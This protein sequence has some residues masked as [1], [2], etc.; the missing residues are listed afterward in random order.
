MLTL[1][2]S[3][4]SSF[5]LMPFIA[6]GAIMVGYNTY[7]FFR[8]H[9][10]LG[11]SGKAEAITSAV[12]VIILNAVIV[13]IPHGGLGK[14]G[15][16]GMLAL[17]IN[18]MYVGVA[19]WYMKK[20]IMNAV[21]STQDDL[22]KRASAFS[23]TAFRKATMGFTALLLVPASEATP[24]TKKTEVA[25]RIKSH[26]A[27]SHLPADELVT[28]F[29]GYLSAI[30]GNSMFGWEDTLATIK[31]LPGQG[32]Q[33]DVALRVAI[34]IV[35]GKTGAEVNKERLAHVVEALG[36]DLANYAK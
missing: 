8:A 19:L 29:S 1:F 4:L 23:T 26:S 20:W 15:P 14:V 17:G 16:I 2:N 5:V 18:L 10:L 13:S 22:T 11:R 32:D 9:P 7:K 25:A 6:F 12:I 33:T 27:L 30:E 36:L 28:L 31:K 21:R 35:G 3:L 24:E 34:N